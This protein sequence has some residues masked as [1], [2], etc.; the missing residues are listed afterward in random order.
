MEN[1]KIKNLINLLCTSEEQKNPNC[2]LYRGSILYKGLTKDF[3]DLFMLLN[4]I[5]GFTQLTHESTYNQT[6]KNDKEM[7]IVSYCEGDIVITEHKTIEDYNRESEE[8]I[9][10]YLEQKN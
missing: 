10:Y 9:N 2:K 6:L 8:I 7:V 4:D 1:V 5:G 3:Y